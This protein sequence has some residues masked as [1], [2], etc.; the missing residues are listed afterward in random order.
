MPLRNDNNNDFLVFPFPKF[1]Q[2]S[3]DKLIGSENNYDETASTVINLAVYLNTVIYRIRYI[4]IVHVNIY[5]STLLSKMRVSGVGIRS[6][7]S[8]LVSFCVIFS[9]CFV[10]S[11]SWSIFSVISRLMSDTAR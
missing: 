4:L 9:I 7:T 5:T 10:F 1:P 3:Q 6:H 8:M 2:T 11:S